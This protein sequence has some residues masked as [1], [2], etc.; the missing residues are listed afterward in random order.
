MLREVWRFPILMTDLA[1]SSNPL[2]LCPEEALECGFTECRVER[3]IPINCNVIGQVRKPVSNLPR[4]TGQVQLPN[5]GLNLAAP[6]TKAGWRNSRPIADVGAGPS[7]RHMEAG[8]IDG[9]GLY[10]LSSASSSSGKIVSVSGTVSCEQAGRR[11]LPLSQTLLAN[12]HYSRVFSTKLFANNPQPIHLRASRPG[13][14]KFIRLLLNQVQGRVRRTNLIAGVVQIQ[15]QCHEM[16]LPF[17]NNCLLLGGKHI[18]PNVAHYRTVSGYWYALPT[19]L[20]DIPIKLQLAVD[21]F[22]YHPLDKIKPSSAAIPE[23]IHKLSCRLRVSVSVF[24]EKC[25]IQSATTGVRGQVT[26][27]KPNEN[28]DVV[29]RHADSSAMTRHGRRISSGVVTCMVSVLTGCPT[30]DDAELAQGRVMGAAVGYV[31][32]HRRLLLAPRIP[33]HHRGT[34]PLP[35]ASLT[36]YEQVAEATSPKAPSRVEATLTLSPIDRQQKHTDKH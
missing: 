22:R 19:S 33:G 8:Q 2:R 15:Y 1:V 4:K 9:Q 23:L 30:G 21:G 36:H 6:G 16:L 29:K 11:S 18:L 34:L 26:P 5:V 14:F 10:T 28:I 12:F 31:A 24:T 32:V 3:C 7:S 17:A 20:Y 35:G 13:H 27:L 25:A